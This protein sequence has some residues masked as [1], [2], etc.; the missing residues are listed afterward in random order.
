MNQITF[1]KD[2]GEAVRHVYQIRASRKAP[3]LRL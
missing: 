1:H 3:D 2:G